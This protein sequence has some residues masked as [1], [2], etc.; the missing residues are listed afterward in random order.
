[1]AIPLALALAALA[2]APAAMALTPTQI[3]KCLDLTGRTGINAR[4]IADGL[5][6]DP[7]TERAV[8]ARV[9]TYDSLGGFKGLDGLG[10]TAEQ[11]AEIMRR[12]EADIAANSWP[13]GSP[14]APFKNRTK[15]IA[16]IRALLIYNGYRPAMKFTNPSPRQIR[17][18]AIQGGVEMLDVVVKTGPRKVLISIRP[19]TGPGGF[20]SVAVP[21]KFDA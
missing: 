20:G 4:K 11:V 2:M 10:L 21:L 13:I 1:V 9:G 3:G 17:V 6:L 19:L 18:R 16:Q 5:G 7:D 15:V 14:C 8:R 12:I